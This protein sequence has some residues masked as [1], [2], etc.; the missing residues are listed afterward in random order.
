MNNQRNVVTWWKR[1]RKGEYV[2]YIFA[3]FLF[4]RFIFHL[5]LFALSRRCAT[6]FTMAMAETDAATETGLSTGNIWFYFTIRR[7]IAIHISLDPWPTHYFISFFFRLLLR[8]L[9]LLLH[10]HFHLRA[11]LVE[12][13]GV[14]LSWE[15]SR[16]EW[17]GVLIYYIFFLMSRV[18]GKRQATVKYEF[19]VHI[20]S[21]DTVFNCRWIFRM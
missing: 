19:K 1:K 4:V 5:K 9:R 17:S 3:I 10:S 8:R 6:L 15:W 20:D 2:V 7:C 13:S 14:E 11:V 18:K 21:A 12:S 16:V